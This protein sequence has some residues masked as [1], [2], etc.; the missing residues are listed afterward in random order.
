MGDFFSSQPHRQNQNKTKHV[1]LFNN[2]I[3]FA[4]SHLFCKILCLYGKEW[5]NTLWFPTR[6]LMFGLFCLFSLYDV[7]Y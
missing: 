1:L 2:E 3:F 6:K 5:D 4:N 7:H